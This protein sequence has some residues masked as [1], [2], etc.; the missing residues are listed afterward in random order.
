MAGASLSKWPA[1]IMISGLVADGTM[2]YD[3]PVNKYLKYWAT[4]D[5]DTRS[6]VTLRDLLTFTSGY[7][8]DSYVLCKQGF[9]EC[10]Q[11]LYEKS[12]HYV[13]PRTTWSYLS[14]HLQFAGAMAVEASGMD[15]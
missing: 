13:A 11:K 12:E 4:D 1:A 5:T 10:A 9:A 15:V 2:S 3:D 7:T 14:C 8:K 6:K